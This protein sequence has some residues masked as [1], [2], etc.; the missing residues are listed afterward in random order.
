VKFILQLFF[1][2]YYRNF[3]KFAKKEKV[4]VED[5]Q[6]V[7]DLFMDIGEAAE[8]LRKYEEKMMIH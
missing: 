6:R 7:D 1:S 2:V 5:V 8:Y 3:T 4:T